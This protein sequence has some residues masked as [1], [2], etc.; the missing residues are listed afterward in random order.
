[1]T[2]TISNKHKKYDTEKEEEHKLKLYW[3]DAQCIFHCGKQLE[4]NGKCNQYI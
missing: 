1:M 2:I 3:L 4:T